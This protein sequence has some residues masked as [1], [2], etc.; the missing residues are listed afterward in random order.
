VEVKPTSVLDAFVGYRA[1]WLASDQD[2]LTTASLKDATGQ[3]GSFVGHQLEARV[4][5]TLLP[6]N[7]AFD[8][9]GAY[10]IHG[11][12]LKDAPNA[13]AGSDSTYFYASTTVTF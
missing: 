6:G 5:Y 8:I 4:R 1:V 10:L 2:S 3:S 13:P 9:G 7:L 12:F 11:K